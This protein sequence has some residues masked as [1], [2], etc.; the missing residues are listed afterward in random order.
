MNNILRKSAT[1]LHL[2]LTGT[3]PPRGF[4][5]TLLTL[6]GLL[7]LGTFF[8]A[9]V[10]GWSY[11]DSLY[12]TVVTIATVGYGDL[13]PTYPA[14]KIFTIFL[15]FMGVGLGIYVFTSVSESFK[16]GREKRIA[17]LESLLNRKTEEN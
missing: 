16:A 8:Y 4:L 11:L 14:S 9:R 17:R 12:F 3:E 13:H 15:I 1:F 7:T 10:E 6:I 5:S 2:N